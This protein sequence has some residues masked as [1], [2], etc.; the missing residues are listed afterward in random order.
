MDFAGNAITLRN[1]SLEFRSHAVDSPY[2]KRVSH[3]RYGKEKQT[4][5]PV[6]L[7]EVCAQSK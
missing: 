2:V 7:I 6:R 4:A 5:K 3:A 1:D